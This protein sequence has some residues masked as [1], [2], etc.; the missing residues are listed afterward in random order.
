MMCAFDDESSSIVTGILDQIISE[1]QV[2]T[3]SNTYPCI[4]ACSDK[5]RTSKL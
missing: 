5:K 3:I 2:S 1:Q 4:L